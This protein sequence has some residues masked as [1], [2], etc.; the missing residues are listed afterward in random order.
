ML[1]GDLYSD[2]CLAREAAGRTWLSI[3]DAVQMRPS[4]AQAA[5]TALKGHCIKQ[6]VIDIADELGYNIIIRLERKE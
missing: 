1:K 4:N 3:A 2:I 5:V 6:S